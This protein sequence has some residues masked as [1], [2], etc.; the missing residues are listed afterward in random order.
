MVRD[1][2]LSRLNFRSPEWQG[3]RCLGILKNMQIVRKRCLHEM[4]KEVSDKFSEKVIG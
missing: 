3:S 4:I 1:Q 2:V